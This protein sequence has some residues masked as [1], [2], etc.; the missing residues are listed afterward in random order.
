M[1]GRSGSIYLKQRSIRQNPRSDRHSNEVICL[2]ACGERLS[3]I[4]YLMYKTSTKL[5]KNI[6]NKKHDYITK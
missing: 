4:P 6:Y 3:G 2:N 1:L 5:V